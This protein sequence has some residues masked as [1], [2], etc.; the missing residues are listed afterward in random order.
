VA[1][2]PGLRAGLAYCSINGE[3]ER[4]A[5]RYPLTFQTMTADLSRYLL[6]DSTTGTVLTAASCYLVDDDSLTPAEWELFDEMTDSE[7]CEFAKSR[8]RKVSDVVTLRA[9][10]PGES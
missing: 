2:S 4:F 8:G 3:P 9:K 1:Q 6:I 10:L 5:S 7:V